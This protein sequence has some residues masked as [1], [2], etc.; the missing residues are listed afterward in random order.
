VITTFLAS[1][2]SRAA[3]SH[4]RISLF[5]CNVR[6]FLAWKQSLLSALLTVDVDVDVVYGRR[7]MPLC[8][9]PQYN[10]S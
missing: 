10:T 3:R 9:P 2:D 4:R 1:Q 8:P 7:R 5:R 6:S